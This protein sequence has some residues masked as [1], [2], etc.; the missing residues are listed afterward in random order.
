VIA[1]ASLLLVM[2]AWL[3]CGAGVALAQDAKKPATPTTI[4]DREAP[5]NGAPGKTSAA[6]P[7]A[8]GVLPPSTTP[9]C[10]VA[11]AR[12]VATVRVVIDGVERECRLLGVLVPPKADED[13]RGHAALENLLAGESVTVVVLPG[14][15]VDR[16]AAPIVQLRREP[17][18]LD[19]NLEVLR[20]GWGSIDPKLDERFAASLPSSTREAYQRAAARAKQLKRGVWSPKVVDAVP[21]DVSPAPKVGPSAT[22]GNA[23]KP[24]AGEAESSLVYVTKSGKKYHRKDCRFAGDDAKGLAVDEAKEKQLEPCAVCR[25]PG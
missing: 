14:V 25:P 20:Q 21:S 19:V 23:G 3:A 18:G 9:G 5:K 8:G 2:S 24:A 16:D 17:E 15:G 12:D 1:R 22:E 4:K 11:G 13:H 7:A 6:V 10:V